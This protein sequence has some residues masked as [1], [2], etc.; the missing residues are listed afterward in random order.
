MEPVEEMEGPVLPAKRKRTFDA[1][2]KLRVVAFAEKNTNRGAAKRFSVEEK[3]VRV[4]R[5]DKSK[6]EVLPE[7]KKRLPGGGR[8]PGQPEMEESLSIWISNL[9]EKNL[10][11]TR[12]QIQQKALELSQGINHSL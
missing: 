12:S 11:V 2:F 7:K 6:L 1:A 3:S 10:R 5:K 9:R 8:K 4:W